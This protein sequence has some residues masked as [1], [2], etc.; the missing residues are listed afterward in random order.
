MFIGTLVFLRPS[1]GSPKAQ[2]EVLT[3][4]IRPCPTPLGEQTNTL[5]MTTCRP[6][7]LKCIRD[8]NGLFT[9]LFPTCYKLW[10]LSVQLFR[11]STGCILA[12]RELADTHT[13]LWVLGTPVPTMEL[14]PR[15]KHLPANALP[16][17]QGQEQTIKPRLLAVVPAFV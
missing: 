9:K 8:M 3:R 1:L 15:I 12:T 2:S 13:F 16:L 5:D 17:A 4:C 10:V 7:P 6:V 14:C 11:I